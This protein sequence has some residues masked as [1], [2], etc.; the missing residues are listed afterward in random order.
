MAS[1]CRVVTTLMAA[2]RNPW[3][4]ILTASPKP[5]ILNRQRGTSSRPHSHRRNHRDNTTG[6]SCTNN[7]NTIHNNNNNNNNKLSTHSK[8][9]DRTAKLVVLRVTLLALVFSAR[10]GAISA[11]RSF[12]HRLRSQNTT[13]KTMRPKTNT[14]V[15]STCRSP[16]TWR[17]S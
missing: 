15:S 1:P 13:L 2:S 12:V 11:R 14:A 8:F 6:K 10:V 4:T 17:P 9:S 16:V 5:T 7:N 3:P